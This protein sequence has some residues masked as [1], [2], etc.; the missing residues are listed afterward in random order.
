[1]RSE[2]TPIPYIPYPINPNT[3]SPV[4]TKLKSVERKSDLLYGSPVADP[5]T[6]LH[7]PIMGVTIHPQ[8]RTIF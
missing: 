3:G 6:G 8:A 1:M 7:S 4:K 2:D 5:I